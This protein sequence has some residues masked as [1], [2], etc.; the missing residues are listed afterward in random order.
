DGEVCCGVVPGGK[1]QQQR[2]APGE[3]R[4]A[5]GKIDQAGDQIG[6][7]T[8]S[9]WRWSTLTQADAWAMKRSLLGA[10]TIP[11]IPAGAIPIG[12]IIICLFACCAL[13]LKANLRGIVYKL[14]RKIRSRVTKR[15]CFALTMRTISQV[16]RG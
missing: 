1:R 6:N 10:S 9:R 16:R 12:C 3:D 4:V 5:A 2:H 13:D 8:A 11:G 14:P 15:P 7:H